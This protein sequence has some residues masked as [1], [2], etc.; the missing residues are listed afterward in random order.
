MTKEIPI[1]NRTTVTERLLLMVTITLL[2]LQDHF[3]SIA[4]FSIMYILFG[5][6]AGYIFLNRPRAL[7]KIY[8][9]PVFLAAYALLIVAFL[10]EFSHPYSDYSH[11]FRI[12]QMIAGA[13]FVASLSRDRGA[14]RAGIYGYLITGAWM[15]IFLFLTTYGTLQEATATD[16]DQASKLRAEVFE[17]SSLRNNP[18]TMGFFSAQGTVV[19][20]ALALTA[21]SSRRRNLFLGLVLFCS[22]ATFLPMSRGA[23]MIAI[24]SCTSVMLAYGVKHIRTIMIVAVLGIGILIWVPDA[25]FSRLV[26]STQSYRGQREARA[27]IYT[28]AIE[29]LPGYIM[30]GVGAG[31]FWESWGLYNGFAKRGVVRGAHNSFLQVAIYWGLPGLLALIMLIYQAYRCL[32]RQCGKNTLSLCLQGIGVSLLLFLLVMHVLSA[33]QFSL[34]LGLLVGARSWIWPEGT[35]LPTSRRQQCLSPMRK[36]V[37]QSVELSSR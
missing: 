33:K 24:A 31:N 32:P 2:P 29:H 17:S 37:R 35:I 12:G 3:P 15:S 19:A 6:L 20:L 22:V 7:A 34:G 8:L 27:S 28:A 25:V 4:G 16:F 1:K 23:I 13:I 9:H 30:T 10:T 14:L 18:N 5:L 26:F 36:P 21:R 11:I